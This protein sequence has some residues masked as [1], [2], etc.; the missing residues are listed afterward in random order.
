MAEVVAQ[1]AEGQGGESGRRSAGFCMDCGY[2][3][4]RGAP[5][6]QLPAG[7]RMGTDSLG[8]VP[9]EQA[10]SAATPEALRW[11][12]KFGIVQRITAG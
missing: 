3:P 2:R 6:L 11:T 1:L 10:R 4:G 9:I 5:S 12:G 7:I 8:D